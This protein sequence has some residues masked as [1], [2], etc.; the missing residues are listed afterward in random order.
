[1]IRKVLDLTAIV[2]LMGAVW[3][4]VISSALANTHDVKEQV[5]SCH[6]MKMLHKTE[7]LKMLAKISGR[8]VQ[9]LQGKGPIERVIG[10]LNDEVFGPKW[11]FNIEPDGFDVYFTKQDGARM[12]VS[13]IDNEHPFCA[14][15]VGP[16]NMEFWNHLTNAPGQ[17]T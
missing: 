6:E 15:T 16:I 1:M 13:V 10:A 9:Q 8:D 2:V 12:L 4:A 11:G 7:A 14:L 5:S 3:G 17:D